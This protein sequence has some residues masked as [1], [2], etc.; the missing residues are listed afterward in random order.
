MSTTRRWHEFGHS[1]EG[2]EFSETLQ[3]LGFVRE[4][5]KE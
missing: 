5:D 3:M 4:F 2:L 1:S